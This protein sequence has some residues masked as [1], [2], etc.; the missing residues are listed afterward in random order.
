MSFEN[1]LYSV[2]DRIAT[3][4]LNR[5]DR[6]NAVSEA[7]IDEIIAALDRADTDDDV[8]VV[9][10][11][12]NGRLFCAGADLSQGASTF[13][14]DSR[15][16]GGSD[17]PVRPD[18]SVDYSHEKVR[19]GAGRLTLRL[20]R[21]LKPVIGAIHG[22]AVGVG[23]TMTLAMDARFAAADTRFGMVFT[24]RGI[25]PEGASTWFLQ[26]I[27]GLDRALD[28]CLTGRIIS[29]S[30]ALEAGLVRSLHTADELL[31][32]AYAYA[33]EI[34]VNTAPV[35]VALTRQML[36]QMAGARHPMEAHRL[37]SRGVY[38]RGRS[39]DAREGVSSFLEKRP[40]TFPNR[41]SR[42]MPDYFPWWD[43]PEYS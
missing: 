20:Y 34:A 40:P 19:D 36:W 3:I 31:P 28:W 5:P 22:A 21:G 29:A 43:E 16:V 18:G 37:D 15:A 17:S 33:R 11:R 32:A 10:V 9:V 25:V 4:A 13:D 42:D 7:M 1:I 6:L 30:E 41:V 24:R 8:R 38:A 26:R 35:S 27:V 23:I 39:D 2:D 14:Y 12:A